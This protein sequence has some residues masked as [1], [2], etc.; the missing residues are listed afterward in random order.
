MCVSL[1]LCEYTNVRVET[2]TWSSS[3]EI[4]FVEDTK[5]GDAFLMRRVSRVGVCLQT[6]RPK[7]RVFSS[8]R[9]QSAEGPWE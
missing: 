3:E 1:D 4:F 7:A 5:V 8:S 6:L 2:Q 9:V